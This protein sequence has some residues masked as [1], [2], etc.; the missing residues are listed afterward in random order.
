MTKYKLKKW[1]PSLPENWKVGDIISKKFSHYSHDDI[2]VSSRILHATEVEAYPE[3]WEKVVEKD[4]EVLSIISNFKYI[5]YKNKNNLYLPKKGI[6]SPGLKGFPLEDVNVPA[7]GLYIH[8]V[9]RLSDGSIWTIGEKTT[10]GVITKF[11]ILDGVLIVFIYDVTWFKLDLLEK[12]KQ[13][14]FK[15]ED[16][17]DI[18][19]GDHWVRVRLSDFSILGIYGDAIGTIKTFSTKEAAEEYILMNQP[20]LCLNDIQHLLK[21]GSSVFEKLKEVV[22]SRV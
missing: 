8:S 21:D 16:G 20:C 5:F 7:N 6:Y 1:Y 3:F 2:G 4:Y 22:K 13:P 17:V 14:L 12:A 15:T 11:E 9:K 18:Y 10:D 19:E